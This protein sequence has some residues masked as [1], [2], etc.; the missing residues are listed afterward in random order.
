MRDL[1][2]QPISS[3]F[4]NRGFLNLWLNQILVQLSYNSLNFALI[5]WV[6]QLTHSNF[7]V[8]A[9]LLA[10][11][12][13]AL[14]F[15]L[16]VGVLVD[17]SDRK[18]IMMVVNILLSGCFFSLIFFKEYYAIILMVAFIINILSQ[19]YAAAESSAI[20]LIVKRHQLLSAN[21][22]FST[23]LFSCFLL[24]FGLAG[25]LINFFDINLLF[26]IGGGLLT[27]AFIMT[28]IFPSIVSQ[29]HQRGEM[30][31]KAFAKRSYSD[32]TQIGLE[33]VIE[34]LRIIKSKL[35]IFS[36]FF[37]LASVQ[38][39]VAIMAVLI[40]DFFEKVLHIKSTDASYVLIMPL[41]IGMVVGGFLMSR[42]GH[43]QP[44]RKIIG[45]AIILAGILFF[46]TGIAPLI[47]PVIKH[48]KFPQTLPFYY[49]PP[50]SAILAT[51]SFLLGL[52]MVSTI[53]PAQTTLQENTP[54]H[55]RGKI[56][57]VLGAAMAGLSILPVLVTGFLADIFG[58]MPIFIGLGGIII[59]FG[60][61][62]LKPTFYFGEKNLP[63]S[64]KELL[65]L[66]QLNSKRK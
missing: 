1:R 9:L 36:S 18:R 43:L 23:T 65:G 33:E 20:P 11:N 32:I 42:F 50:L 25:P 56:F 29:A 55:S 57:A 60:L 62:I 14:L 66:R 30:L 31:I 51:G 39:V 49:Q 63:H 27:F 4:A 44:R 2:E 38:V 59:L 6:F 16:F 22:L 24:G 54:E 13:P 19:V 40:P 8:S 21:S 17:I 48:I 58:T 37:I 26:G 53:V 61:F 64:L 12:L 5:I 35:I 34:T 28:F 45:R 3:V 52:T 46:I 7:A 41:G 10:I 15:G 47:A